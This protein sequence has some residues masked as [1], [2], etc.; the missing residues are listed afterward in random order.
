MFESVCSMVAT[1]C[2]HTTTTQTKEVA[3]RYTLTREKFPTLQGVRGILPPT[4]GRKIALI[5]MNEMFTEL[6][7]NCENRKKGVTK[8]Y[9]LHYLQP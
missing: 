3:K 2:P 6:R 8:C 4:G 1:G 7:G 5:T 9:T